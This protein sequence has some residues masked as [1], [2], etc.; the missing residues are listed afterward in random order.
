MQQDSFYQETLTQGVALIEFGHGGYRGRCYYSEPI[1][2][3]LGE[4]TVRLSF[5]ILDEAAYDNAPHTGSQLLFGDLSAFA[6]S[7]YIPSVPNMKIGAVLFPDQGVFRIGVRLMENTAQKSVRIVWWASR[8]DAKARPAAIL[9]DTVLEDPSEEFSDQPDENAF[10][11]TNAPRVLRLRESFRF[12]LM[13]PKSG[14]T[15]VWT[16]KEA[17]GGTITPDGLYTAPSAPGIFEIQ[18]SLDDQITSVYIMVRE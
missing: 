7:S 18:A 2:H 16:I 10:Y 4:G 8:L 11:I 9:P 1:A 15:P 5:A 12:R 6:E 17:G 13:L 14:G 3:G